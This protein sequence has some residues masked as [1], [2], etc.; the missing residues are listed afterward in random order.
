MEGL[1]DTVVLVSLPTVDEIVVVA[2]K[3][4][5]S[6]PSGTHLEMSVPLDKVQFMKTVMEETDLQLMDS[7]E[8]RHR[9]NHH[10]L[11]LTTF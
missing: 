2:S 3:H 7:A 5:R 10:P 6:D 9:Q 11:F 1:F 4:F 8:N